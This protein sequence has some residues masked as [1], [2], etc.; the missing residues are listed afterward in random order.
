MLLVI[1]KVS[2]YR[3]RKCVLHKNVDWVAQDRTPM[4]RTPGYAHALK[5][6]QSDD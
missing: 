1:Q 4:Q 2:L 3:W 5:E 6:T